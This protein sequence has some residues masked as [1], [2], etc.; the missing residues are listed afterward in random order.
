MNTFKMVGSPHEGKYI[1][2]YQSKL[3][4]IYLFYEP[5]SDSKSSLHPTERGSDRLA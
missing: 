1:E 2:I 3:F 5:F 4:I